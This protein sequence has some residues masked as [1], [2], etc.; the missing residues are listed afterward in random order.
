MKQRI[1]ATRV[2]NSGITAV[3]AY[4]D[5]HGLIFQA[6]PREDFGI[7]CYIEVELASQPQNFLIGLQ[8]KSGPSH[9]YDLKENAFAIRV[10]QDDAYYWLAANY[11]VFL[12]YFDLQEQQ[13]YFRHVQ[14]GFGDAASLAEC[15]SLGFSY[16]NLAEPGRMAEY[17]RTLAK[18][19][20]SMLNRFRVLSEEARFSIGRSSVALEPLEQVAFDG[21][22]LN[23][24]IFRPSDTGNERLSYPM[25]PRTLGYSLDERWVCESNIPD[26]GSR[27]SYDVSISFIDL[28]NYA[29]VEISLISADE[30]DEACDPSGHFDWSQYE[31]TLDR[32]DQLAKLLDIRRA[33]ILFDAYD[34]FPRA[35]VR[36]ELRLSFG[37]EEFLLTVGG[38]DGRHTLELVA[39]R[40]HPPRSAHL[41]LERVPLAHIFVPDAPLRSRDDLFQMTHPPQFEFVAG[42]ASSLAGGV[43]SFAV[44]TNDTHGC[45]GTRTVHLAHLSLAE[46]RRAC[47]A[48][49][50]A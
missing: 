7:D 26:P 6:E 41:L 42:V 47:A 10:R 32:A 1:R 45:W 44:M 24:D 37:D 12:V 5:Q 14:A 4:C 31:R 16:E 8:V 49:L 29:S 27:G 35:E 15:K 34:E 40:F 50:R 23:F 38:H 43:A 21:E 46:I 2:G 9:R 28:H 30:Y 39:E 19:T 18:A 20:P 48:A 3:R 36:Q 33:R 17:A 25:Y 22:C 11:P 13:L